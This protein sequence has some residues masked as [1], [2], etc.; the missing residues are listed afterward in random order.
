VVVGGEQA[1]ERPAAGVYA[2]GNVR[3][4]AFVVAIV[5][6]GRGRAEFDAGRA[7]QNMLLA[8]WNEG[9]GGVPNG[10]SDAD[11]V[12]ELLSLSGDQ[13][14]S[15]VLTFGY[16]ARRRDP[17]RRSPEEWLARADRRPF[18]DVVRVVD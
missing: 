11:A 7:T 14:V 12:N 10:V 2:P 13:R 4:A 18:D 9:V 1:R 17:G 8:A 16:P 5:V 6:S 15:I 3:G